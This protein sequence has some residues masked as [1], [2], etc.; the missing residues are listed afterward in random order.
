MSFEAL[1][2]L[3]V[4]VWV[5]GALASIFFYVGLRRASSPASAPS[6]VR[7]FGMAALVA[8]VAYFV[9]AA[10]GIYGAC[11]SSDSGSLC[12]LWGALGIGPLLSGIALWGY[13]L[14]WRRSLGR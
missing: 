2:V 1:L 3:G 14:L 4:A 13:G 5:T 11:S 7:Y 12:G 6:F 10:I 8:F 9:G